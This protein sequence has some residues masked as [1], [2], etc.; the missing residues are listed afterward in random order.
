[1][2]AYSRPPTSC[3]L[4][5]VASTGAIVPNHFCTVTT[6]PLALN[7]TPLNWAGPTKPMVIGGEWVTTSRIAGVSIVCARPTIGGLRRALRIADR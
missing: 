5:T 2:W 4:L 6:D 3:V 7:V 1:M